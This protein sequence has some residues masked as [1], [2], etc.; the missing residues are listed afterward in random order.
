[1]TPQNGNLNIKPLTTEQR[2]EQTRLYGEALRGQETITRATTVEKTRA[3][4]EIGKVTSK[5]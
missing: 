1:M 4:G 2:A 3:L 5:K